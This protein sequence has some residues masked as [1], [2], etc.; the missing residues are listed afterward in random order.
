MTYVLP[1][2]ARKP[3][4]ELPQAQLDLIAPKVALLRDAILEHKKLGIGIEQLKNEIKDLM[5]AAE[6]GTISGVPMIRYQKTAGIAW[7]KFVA[8]NPGIAEEYTSLR[9][10]PALDEKRLLADHPDLVNRYA[11]RNFSLV[12]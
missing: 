2:K 1:E 4:K 9:E 5:G 6:E 8:D 12:S 10:V 3:K 11:I 7:A